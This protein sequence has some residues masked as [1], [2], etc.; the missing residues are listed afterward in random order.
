MSTPTKIVLDCDPGHDDAVALLLA[1][2]DPRIDLLAVTTIGGNQTL[3]KVTRNTLG[4]LTLIGCTDV[5][6]AA[7]CTRPLVRE[8]RVAA[9]I[10]GESGLD[11]VDLPEPTI[12]LDP[13][14]AVDVIIETVMAH[15]PGEVTLVPTGPLTNIALAARREPAIIERV[16]EVVLMG[17]GVHVGNATPV[18]EFNILVDPEA[19]DIVFGAGWPVVMV[20]LDVTHEALATPQVAARVAQI[21]SVAG[22]FVG[23]LIEA[24]GENYR[25]VQGFDAPPVHDPCALAYVIDNSIVGTRRAPLTVELR[26]EHTTGMTVA[27]LRG[28]EP[29]DCPTSVGVSLDVDKFWDLVV[30]ALEELAPGA[31]PGASPG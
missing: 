30:G 24:F 16:R 22:R 6:V 20:G 26:G 5:P 7:G 12:T 4:I 13:R 11:G 1:H 14:H 15:G 29:A 9:D 25:Q 18:A 10:H 8:M 27:D 3:E 19:A 28:P 23:Q 2:A 17:G 21:D 31:Q